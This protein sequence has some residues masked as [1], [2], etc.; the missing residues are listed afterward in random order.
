MK[1]A[2]KSEAIEAGLKAEQE[3]EDARIEY[4]SAAKDLKRHAAE[5]VQAIGDR[6]FGFTLDAVE[7]HAADLDA[8]DR[9]ANEA[10]DAKHGSFLQ[11]G[12]LLALFQR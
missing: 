9:A 12:A 5:A 11:P 1:T 6:T 3:K 8:S 4:A 10:A 7:A 2:S